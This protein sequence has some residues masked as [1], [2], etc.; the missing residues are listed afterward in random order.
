MAVIDRG[1]SP[2]MSGSQL[3]QVSRSIQIALQRWRTWPVG[4]RLK[5]ILLACGRLAK[6][7][8]AK[9]TKAKLL[10][11]NETVALGDRRFVSVIE[12][13]GQRF[14]IGSSPAAV[15]LIA[16][17]ENASGLAQKHCSEESL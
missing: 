14:L 17:L 12:F 16:K 4:A 1:L 8:V 10:A 6:E 3:V 5:R 2:R 15:T 7:G 11:V 9:R 13:E